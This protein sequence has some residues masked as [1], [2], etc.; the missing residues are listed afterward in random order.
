M[1]LPLAYITSSLL[2]SAQDVAFN[3]WCTEVGVLC[4]SVEVRT[5]PQSVAGRGVFTTNDVEEGD[6]V[7][8][9]PYYSALTQENGRKYFPDIA[10]QLD[11]CRTKV[12]GPIRRAWN[13]IRGK[14]EVDV[15]DDEQF[16][17]AELSAYA[18]EA[19]RTNHPW[20]SWISQWQRDDPY[21]QLVDMSTWRSDDEVISKS[22]EDFSKIAP[23]I[24]HYKVNAA[25]GIR[26]ARL[27]DYAVKYQNKVPYSES[28][29]TTLTS[30]AIDISDG[31]TACLPMHDMINHSFDPNISMQF[32]DGYFEFIALQ[33]I[34]KDTELFISY[35]DV[36]NEG[37]WDEDKATWMLVQ[38]GIPTSP[39][40]KTLES[41]LGINKR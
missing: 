32:N 11:K 12:K 2:P 6:T 24:S 18:L 22:L 37:I 10:K 26:L 33:N 39:D 19:V 21:Q 15:L 13:R 34:A 4:P 23:H 5:T 7:L 36:T 35:M 14:T 20:S 17:Q 40:I 25:I 29:Y 8:S 16:W 3:S 1:K 30:R 9:I 28:L 38:W 41:N 27:N 31:V